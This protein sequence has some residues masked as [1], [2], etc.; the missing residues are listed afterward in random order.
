[1]E[2]EWFA[3]AWQKVGNVVLARPGLIWMACFGVMLPFALV[4]LRYQSHLSYGLLSELPDT[5]PCVVGAKAIQNHFPA[6]ITGPVTVLIENREK[7][8]HEVDSWQLI[9]D[10]ARSLYDERRHSIL[11]ISAAWLSRWE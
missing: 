8:F 7:N 3:S 5:K 1:M 6:G 11:P 9:G 4:S 2:K 10:L